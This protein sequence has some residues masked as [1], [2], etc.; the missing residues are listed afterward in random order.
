MLDPVVCASRAGSL[1][2]N[3]KGKLAIN[4]QVTINGQALSDVIYEIVPGFI[5]SCIF[6]VG[7]S[8]R[9]A[10]PTATICQTFD[11]VDREL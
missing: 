6:T 2:K 8:L 1:T 5:V 9:T 11:S 10:K 3:K 7:V 4:G